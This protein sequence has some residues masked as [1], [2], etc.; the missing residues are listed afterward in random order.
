MIKNIN[1]YS[2]KPLKVIVS[3]C[4]GTQFHNGKWLPSAI[5]ANQEAIEEGIQIIL[6]SGKPYNVMVQDVLTSPLKDELHKNLHLGSFNGN[7]STYE[8]EVL[9]DNKIPHNISKL[10]KLYAMLRGING[11]FSTKEKS[12]VVDIKDEWLLEVTDKLRINLTQGV[13]KDEQF[14]QIELKD[15]LT[16]NGLKSLAVILDDF[17]ASNS[18]L[19]PV[20]N[21]SEDYKW[22][23]FNSKF[24]KGNII[25]PYADVMGLEPQEFMTIGDGEN[26]KD[27]IENTSATGVWMKNTDKSIINQGKNIYM[28]D[29]VTNNGYAKA[30]RQ[31]ILNK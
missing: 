18:F 20:D 29:S 1:G 11:I 6:A 14:Y 5:E 21:L 9:I 22:L 24:T 10:I 2:G 26:D 7:L 30:V 31:L 17:C 13:P 3:D 25:K 15:D 28:T 12:Y 16:Y 27:M 8:G 19:P 23:Q 4:D